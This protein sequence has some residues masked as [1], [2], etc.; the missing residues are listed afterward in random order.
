M[1]ILMHPIQGEYW[2]IFPPTILAARI[3][4]MFSNERLGV[5]WVRPLTTSEVEQVLKLKGA[6]A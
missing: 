2:W 5:I 4:A 6:A 1:K 3:R